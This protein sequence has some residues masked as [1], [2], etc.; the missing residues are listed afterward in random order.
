MNVRDLIKQHEGFSSVVYR[1][2]AG[3]RTIGWGHNIDAHPLPKDIA[4]RLFAN[5]VLLPD[6]AER[7]LTEDINRAMDDCK[8]LY[9]AFDSFTESRKAALCDFVF[10][11]G[12]SVAAQ[13]KK[14]KVAILLGKW[15]EAANEMQDSNW[16]RQVRD[17]SK[18]IVKMVREG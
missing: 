18:T 2:P 9:P 3:K 4:G 5:G 1:C 14:M 8:R 10:N 13:F 6:D 12:G 15:N 11:V 7:L 16:F 17:R